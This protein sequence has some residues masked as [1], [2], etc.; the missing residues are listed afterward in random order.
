MEHLSHE[1]FEQKQARR[2]KLKFSST[3]GFKKKIS[4]IQSI[5]QG[6]DQLINLSSYDRFSADR[7]SLLQEPPFPAP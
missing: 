4:V 6:I 5:S 2:E 1:I 7:H 3:Q